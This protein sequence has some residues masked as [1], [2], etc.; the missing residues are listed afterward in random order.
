[1]R[2]TFVNL[3]WILFQGHVTSLQLRHTSSP[4]SEV[5]NDDPSLWTVLKED[6]RA[7][8]THVYQEHQFS[9]TVYNRFAVVSFEDDVLQ[10]IGQFTGVSFDTTI[11]P[12]ASVGRERIMHCSVLHPLLFTFNAL[13]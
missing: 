4:S 10:D 9:T 6:I 5:L 8:D 11:D 12:E 13:Q 2:E 3:T 1:M 7:T